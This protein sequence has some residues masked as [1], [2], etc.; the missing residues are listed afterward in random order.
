MYLNLIIRH[1]VLLCLGATFHIASAVASPVLSTTTS[2]VTST[3]SSSP[4][5]TGNY[6]A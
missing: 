2:Y 6:D 3:V 1:N 5:G 4:Q